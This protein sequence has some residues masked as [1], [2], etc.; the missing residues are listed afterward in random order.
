MKKMTILKEVIKKSKI[1]TQYKSGPLWNQKVFFD[2]LMVDL[3]SNLKSQSKGVQNVTNEKTKPLSF[4][5]VVTGAIPKDV[6]FEEDVEIWSSDKEDVNMED[7][8]A[9]DINQNPVEEVPLL[10]NVVIP[11]KLL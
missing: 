11:P 9:L 2:D 4:K 7:S 10:P 5:E 6:Y 1:F 3:N 8:Q